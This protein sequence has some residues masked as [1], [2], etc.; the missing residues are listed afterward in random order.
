L[1]SSGLVV[2]FLERG[3]DGHSPSSEWLTVAAAR[4]SQDFFSD[5]AVWNQFLQHFPLITLI[6]SGKSGKGVVE[7]RMFCRYTPQLSRSDVVT[8]WPWNWDNFSIPGLRSKDL[9]RGNFEFRVRLER[10]RVS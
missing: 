9:F 5:Q 6:F 7:K 8:G 3:G 1:F 4:F 10:S 2:R